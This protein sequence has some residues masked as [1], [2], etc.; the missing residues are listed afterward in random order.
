M[1]SWWVLFFCHFHFHCNVCQLICKC[2]SRMVDYGWAHLFCINA[3][4]Q[5]RFMGSGNVQK[6]VIFTVLYLYKCI[7]WHLCHACLI[8]GNGFTSGKVTNHNT[9]HPNKRSR[10]QYKK[11]TRGFLTLRQTWNL[12]RRDLRIMNQLFIYLMYW[13]LQISFLLEQ[14][15]CTSTLLFYMYKIRVAVKSVVQGSLSHSTSFLW[16]INAKTTLCVM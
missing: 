3:D 10:N 7:S 14:Q 8:P 11:T 9:K 1:V 5:N 4:M 2:C 16:V 15:Q 13:L 12:L 6:D